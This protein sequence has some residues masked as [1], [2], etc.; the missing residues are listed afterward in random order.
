MIIQIRSW[1]WHWGTF[2]CLE[3]YC[4]TEGLTQKGTGTL[5][6]VESYPFPIQRHYYTTSLQVSGLKIRRLFNVPFPCTTWNKAFLKGQRWLAIHLLNIYIYICMKYMSLVFIVAL[7]PL[8]SDTSS[9]YLK[10]VML[11]LL[12]KVLQISSVSSAFLPG[13]LHLPGATNKS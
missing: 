13:R 2:P 8:K 4:T 9:I 7:A 12:C 5:I 3:N 11:E 6:T 10:M 1:Y